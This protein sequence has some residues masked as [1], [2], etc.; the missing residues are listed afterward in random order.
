MAQPA[1]GTTWAGGGFADID[2]RLV[3]RGGLQ[4]VLIRD[5]LGED[6]N[7]SPF[8]SFSG[9]TFE[10][11]AAGAVINFSPFAQDY[12]PRADLIGAKLVAGKWV[13]NPNANA[14]F[15]SIGSQ[16]E[17]GGSE[18]KPDTKSDD[19]KILQSV[20]PIDTAITE[21][22]LTVNFKAVEGVKP[23]LQHLENEQPLCDSSGTLSLPD[24]GAQHYVTGPAA[25]QDPIARQLLLWYAK[26][27]DGLW[28]YQVEGVASAK[29]D[30]QGAKKR[31]KTDPDV[32]DLTF[33]STLNPYFMVPVFDRQSDAWILAPGGSHCVWF[34]GPAWEAFGPSGS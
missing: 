3:S 6:S 15:L 26:K 9:A 21:K 8:T 11:A 22:S 34:G 25:D 4:C 29:L 31:T 13:K 10:A 2:P 5:D 1:T 23:L 19:L 14:G 16:T 7:I 20:F 27:V 24:L 18:R 12:S 17:D 28:L 30:S 33:K 32:T